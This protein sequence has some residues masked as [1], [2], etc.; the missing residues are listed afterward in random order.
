[1]C[2]Q[3]LNIICE[4]KE[5]LSNKNHLIRLD[6]IVSSRNGLSR[7]IASWLIKSSK[8]LVDGQ[9]CLSPAIKVL[10]S[11]VVTVK[12]D[13][14]SNKI[15]VENFVGKNATGNEQQSQYNEQQ[16]QYFSKNKSVTAKHAPNIVLKEIYCDDNLA[17]IFKPPNLNSHPNSLW[18]DNE[19]SV[20]GLIKE[21]YSHV[22]EGFFDVT[23]ERAQAFSSVDLLHQ[24]SIFPK[25]IGD[26]RQKD[27][28]D[29]GQGRQNIHWPG[30][31]HRLDRDTSGLM[32]VALN[33]SAELNLRRQMFEKIIEK[34]YLLIGCRDQPEATKEAS[35]QS[36]TLRKPVVQEVMASGQSTALKKKFLKFEGCGAIVSPLFKK[37][38]RGRNFRQVTTI[39]TKGAKKLNAISHYK[40]LAESEINSS[41]FLC[42]VRLE[43]GYTHQIRAHMN[44]V[45][46]FVFGDKIY[47][48]K[49]EMAFQPKRQMLH[50]RELSFLHPVT[51][52]RLSFF[53]AP[54][55]DFLE[56][57]QQLAF[58]LWQFIDPKSNL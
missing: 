58:K 48:K 25:N 29:C 16:S 10:S 15:C 51:G 8:V 56:C 41:I 11:S 3:D 36:A 22:E 55:E 54:S 4:E 53:A 17:V 35:G 14:L 49:I 57:G 20:Y 45:D 44:A 42:A 38:V 43:T 23:S 18:S 6:K 31:V 47:G 5:V 24:D 13:Y 30:I 27:K 37:S 9:I 40:V 12:D 46:A 50:A 21:K 39:P 2:S 34:E 28:H 1:M 33:R 19:H 52:E 7:S 26:T 32:V